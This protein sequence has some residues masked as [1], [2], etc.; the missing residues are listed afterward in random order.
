MRKLLLVFLMVGSVSLFVLGT[1]EAKTKYLKKTEIEETMREF[2]RALGVDCNFCH[3]SDPSK[4]YKDLA[5]K[6]FDEKELTILVHQRIARAMLGDMLYYNEKE[7]RNLTC[8]S[9]HQGKTE[10]RIPKEK[11]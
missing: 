9:C 6:T 8:Y 5:G 3:V 11:K 7:G 2:N 4:T 1:V 10:V